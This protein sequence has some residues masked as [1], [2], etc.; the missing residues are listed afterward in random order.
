M[1]LVFAHA[2]E[3]VLD[4]LDAPTA[5]PSPLTARHAAARLPTTTSPRAACPPS[6]AAIVIVLGA[7]IADLS[8]GH[9][10]RAE[11]VQF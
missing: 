10:W 8:L 2:V 7:T 9:F 3:F 11:V 1:A 4:V 6:R 5:S